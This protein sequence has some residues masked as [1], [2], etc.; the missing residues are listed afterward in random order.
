MRTG[1]LRRPRPVVMTTQVARPPVTDLVS[2]HDEI[3]HVETPAD[4][5]KLIGEIEAL[6]DLLRVN[7]LSEEQERAWKVVRLKAERQYGVVLGPPK[8]GRGSNVSSSY[9]S[10]AERMARREA[11]RVAAIPQDQFDGYIRG[12]KSPSRSGLLASDE[13]RQP[14]SSLSDEEVDRKAWPLFDRGVGARA[15]G[16]ELGVHETPIKNSYQRWKGAK[17]VPAAKN[18]RQ[19]NWNGKSNATRARE[20]RQNDLGKLNQF[21]MDINRLCRVLESYRPDDYTPD[22]DSVWHIAAI[23][24]DLISLGEWVSR[25]LSA[26]QGWL[27]DSDVRQ[28]IE[29]LRNTHGR[30]PEEAETAKR[31]ADLLE[32][33]LGARLES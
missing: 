11:R 19:K 16:R 6:R 4:A 24:E 27:G 33:K 2:A 10:D 28:K 14:R 15:A 8:R 5:E 22:E 7:R 30:T 17:S 31:L 26:T 9:I 1:P 23:Y 3:P 13:P 12:A 20:I 25:S 29:R 32:R 18:G 21:A